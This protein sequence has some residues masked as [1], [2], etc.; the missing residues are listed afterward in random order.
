MNGHKLNA[1]FRRLAESPLAMEAP[2]ILARAHLLKAAQL[3]AG[4]RFSTRRP[5]ASPK[6]IRTEASRDPLKTLIWVEGEGQPKS[7]PVDMDF[8]VQR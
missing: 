2:F 6:V 3:Q 1:Y 7:V 8:F 5:P 4:D